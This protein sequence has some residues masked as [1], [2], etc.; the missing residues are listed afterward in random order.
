[1]PDSQVEFIEQ[2]SDEIESHT[3]RVFS[4]KRVEKRF[5]FWHLIRMVVQPW[6]K[7][8]VKRANSAQKYFCKDVDSREIENLINEQ[9]V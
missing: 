7:S 5:G 6:F 3:E 9:Y 4:T 8:D 1:M 2:L